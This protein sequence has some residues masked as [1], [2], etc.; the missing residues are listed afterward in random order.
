M[1][2]YMADPDIRTITKDGRFVTPD[3]LD[4]A[5][6][7]RLNR[8]L[9][10]DQVLEVFYRQNPSTVRPPERDLEAAAET[11]M[12]VY[13]QRSARLPVGWQKFAVL[14]A[15]IAGCPDNLDSSKVQE[16]AYTRITEENPSWLGDFDDD[17][18]RGMPLRWL[19]Q[20]IGFGVLNRR[21]LMEEPVAPPKKR[22]FG[23]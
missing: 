11:A 16:W 7:D 8:F 18:D 12:A 17:V 21:R 4:G 22:W 5:E 10:C 6:A 19:T 14:Q 15:G 2:D 3:D 23:R 1:P 13:D 9:E 20:L